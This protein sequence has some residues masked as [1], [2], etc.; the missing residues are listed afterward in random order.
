MTDLGFITF[1]FKYG[2]RS[3]LR[4]KRRSILL[5]MTVV[6][7]VM[8]SLVSYS[9]AE[10]VFD[11][12]ILSTI[13]SGPGQAQIVP[14]GSLEEGS[15]LTPDQLFAKG[16][17]IE[18]YL[19]G[20]ESVRAYSPRLRVDGLI[21][22]GSKSIYFVGIGIDVLKERVISPR[23]IE[24][25]GNEGDMTAEPE[26]DVI[27]LGRS[28][29]DSLGLQVGDPVFL[30]AYTTEGNLNAQSARVS[31][32]I[33]FQDDLVSKRL[34][35]FPINFARRLVRAPDLYN[36]IVI[37]LDD[38]S[39]LAEWTRLS[40]DHIL[41][42][43]GVLMPWWEVF[44]P[45]RKI[46]KIWQSVVGVISSLLFL[47]SAISVMT[48]ILLSVGERTK[49]I[50]LLAALGAR[51]RDIRRIFS[52]ESMMMASIGTILGLVCFGIYISIVS[53]AGIPMENPFFSGYIFIYPK[54]SL[55]VSLVV[56]FVCLLVCGLSSL[57]PVIKAANTDPVTAFRGQS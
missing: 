47:L 3:L 28:L 20:G 31:A 23:L 10:A 24:F 7:A 37:R 43:G 46:E 25:E 48:I 44:P 53:Q 12:W 39:D 5:I 50:G 45:M 42:H 16:N 17:P 13:E 56:F 9:Y 38:K 26:G 8:A 1:A 22:A 54:F 4:K 14:K 2:Y 51:K 18:S 52:I 41:D 55:L 34:I 15:V 57:V 36:Q 21:S 32:I 35:Y 11:Y 29:A 19:A 49:E 6:L 33:N 40:K 27:A 30:S